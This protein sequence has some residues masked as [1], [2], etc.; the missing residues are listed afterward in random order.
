M[1]PN[2]PYGESYDC[3]PTLDDRQ[4]IEFCK[5]GYL[6]LEKVVPDEINRKTVRY[7]DE[8]DDTY[9]PTPI[10]GQDW[11]TE[12]VLKNPQ[13][14]GAVRSLLGKG[15][16]LPVIVSNHRGRLPCGYGGWHRDG[17]SIYT[18]ELEYL[19]VFYYP[20]DCPLECGPTEVFPGSHF[21]R[22]KA[23]MMGNLGHIQGAVPVSAPAGTIFLTIYSIWHRRRAASAS[24][25][26]EYKFRNLLKYNYWRT[27]PPKRDWKA[28]PNFDFS[29][30]DF[31]PRSGGFEQFQ[32]G[33]AAARM[34][35]WLAGLEDQYEKRGGQ[36]WPIALTV[37][38][39]VE[40]M[41]LPAGLRKS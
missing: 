5:N 15:F 33:I 8:V 26:P 20:Q 18:H 40:Q 12:G 32:G 3:E 25:R 35:C 39:G 21:M 27:A 31:N 13:A 14:A 19:Q 6:V 9:E 38:N 24:P 7:L 11:F 34:F 2:I 28:D 36:C 4:V 23:T 41:G 17:G 29:T 22:L 1:K 30:I 16:V 10:M 37:R